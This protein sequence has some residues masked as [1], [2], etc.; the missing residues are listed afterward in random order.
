MILGWIC[1][2]INTKFIHVRMDQHFKQSMYLSWLTDDFLFLVFWNLKQIF[3][4]KCYRRKNIWFGER[5]TKNLFSLEEIPWHIIFLFCKKNIFHLFNIRK[6]W[7]RKNL[8]NYLHRNVAKNMLDFN[9]PT[10]LFENN[11]GINFSS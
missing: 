4:L 5:I 11:Y 6:N 9:H 1:D 7:N 3:E 2:S 10:P 8:C